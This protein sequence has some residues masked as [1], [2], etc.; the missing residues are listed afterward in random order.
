MVGRIDI[1]DSHKELAYRKKRI[2]NAIEICESNKK[3]IF[4]FL[5]YCFATGLSIQRAVIYA[6]KIFTLAKLLE[7]DFKEATKQDILSLVGKVER[8]EKWSFWTKHFYKVTIKKFYKWL[9]GEGEFYPEKV[10]WMKNTN[11]K[12]E[13]LLPEDLPT[14]EEIMKLI[15]AAEN[16]RDK[17]IIALFADAGLRPT[18]LAGIRI[19][20]LI[21]DE[22]GIKVHVNGK[23]GARIVRLVD[24]VKWITTWLENY[25]MDKTNPENYLWIKLTRKEKGQNIDYPIIRKVIGKAAHRA[26]MKKRVFAYALRHYC[27]TNLAKQG[28]GEATMSKHMGWIIGTK[29]VRSYV[30]LSTRDTDSAILGARGIKMQENNEMKHTCK[31]CDT[32]LVDLASKFCS[33][34][35]MPTTTQ[36]AYGAEEDQRK[37]MEKLEPL[38]EL[39]K[40]EDVKEFLSNKLN[41]TT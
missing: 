15:D 17:A 20:D 2:E 18:E 34:C 4:E 29:S 27:G 30:H 1:Y 9:E 41:K 36:A 16:P 37:L 7:K 38:M 32:I 19:K 25:P 6:D 35:G 11:Y 10:R 22:Y 24:S 31:R 39:M 8:N 3:Y 12:G 14:R 13:R 28:I 40:D 26:G 23:T 33:K 5:D 21:Y